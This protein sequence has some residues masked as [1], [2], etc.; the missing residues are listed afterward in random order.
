MR[1]MV[2][3]QEQS[4]HV[5]Y[6]QG[7]ST[8]GLRDVMVVPGTTVYVHKAGI[9]YVLGSVS[10]P[11]GYLMISGGT[12]DVMQALALAQGTIP[13]AAVGSLLIVRK[14]TDGTIAEIPVPYKQIAGG[15]VKAAIL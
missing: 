1:R 6:A 11:G 7:N 12:L 8:E 3:G 5:T 4:E 13:T 2:N 10:R 14:N 15:K 9:I